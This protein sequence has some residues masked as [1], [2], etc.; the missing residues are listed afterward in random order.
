MLRMHRD[1]LIMVLYENG[2]LLWDTVY[3][4]YDSENESSGGRWW[5][6]RG[7]DGWGM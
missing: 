2:S 3:D 1:D 5:T 6:W 4:R 7:R